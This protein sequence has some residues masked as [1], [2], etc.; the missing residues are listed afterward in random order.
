M[1]CTLVDKFRYATEHL[2]QHIYEQTQYKSIWLNLIPRGTCTM[3]AGTHF[4]VFGTA[5]LEPTDDS[6]EWQPI[7]LSNQ[8]G[9]GADSYD[10]PTEVCTNHWT[11]VAYGH[12]E[13][14]YHPEGSKL[15]GPVV[16]ADEL[17]F[18]HNVGAFLD[19]YQAKMQIRAQRQWENN[20]AYHHRRLSRKAEIIA[21]FESSFLDQEGLTGMNGATG[22]LTQEALEII[23]QYLIEDDTLQPD[24]QGFTSLG[25]DGPIFSMYIGMSQSQRILRQNSDLRQ[26][27]RFGDPNT[28]LSRIGATKV[29]GNFRHVINLRPARYTFSNGTYTRVNTFEDN[30]SVTVGTGQKTATA[31]REAPYEGMDILCPALF[32][33]EIV[34]PTNSSGGNTK[35]DPVSYMGEWEL[36][37]GAYKWAE[38]STAGCDDPLGRKC[39]HYAVFK[40]AVRHN[41]LLKWKGGWHVI[42]KRCLGNEIE[43]TTCSS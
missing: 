20:Y 10:T 34:P 4:S 38:D 24:T 26:D 27:Y 32:T 16:C 19:S 5:Q 39:R 25:E 40:H 36:V 29:I 17:E 42:Y 7:D 11:D 3:G 12:I 31:W 6:G 37:V 21:D 14:T 2:D 9:S 35:F 18:A 41:P 28:L 13:E 30:G 23:A 15:R 8:E 33:S 22:E 43:L 1:A